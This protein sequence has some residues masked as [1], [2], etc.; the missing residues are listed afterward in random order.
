MLKSIRSEKLNNSTNLVK[1]IRKFWPFYLFFVPAI[2][3]YG[4]FAY[5]P[6]T[7]II[8]A[9]KD[10]QFGKGFFGSPWVGFIYFEDF[11]MNPHFWDIV[12][13]TLVIS[14]SRLVFNFPAPIILALMINAVTAQRFKRVIQTVSYL[15]HFVAWVVVAAL[16][17]AFFSPTTGMINDL[18]IAQNLEPIFFLGERELFLP[19][20]VLSEMWKSVGF[21]AIIYLAA[22]AGI[23]PTLYEA[24][25]IDGANGRQKLWHIT[26]PG[27]S[28]T[29]GILF[30]FS[31]GGLLG[32]NMEQILLLQT[33]ATFEVSEVIDTFVLRRGLMMNQF[34]YA[35]AVS[36]FR[37]FMSLIIVIS[38]NYISKKFTGVSIW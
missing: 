27:I 6:M 34:D 37:S 29:I 20:I 10:F 30:L 32:V 16:I 17:N 25:E 3:W 23:D 14:L 31:I 26:F 36:L 28:P 12:R 24:A 2:I 9:F 38:A 11:I 33:P 15:P 22:L 7:G 13:N 8:I 18:R 4:I 35:T 21:S 1:T 19:F 5:Y